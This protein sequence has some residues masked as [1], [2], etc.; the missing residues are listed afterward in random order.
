MDRH[1]QGVLDLAQQ[2]GQVI[3]SSTAPRGYPAA[4]KQDFTRE[5]VA[6]HPEHVMVFVGLE[7]IQSKDDMA[8][9]LEDVLETSLVSEAQSEQLLIA[10]QKIGDGTLG[11]GNSALL[12]DAMDFGDGAMLM[13]AQGADE[14]DDVKAEFAVG[15]GPCTFLFRAN[16]LAVTWAGRIVAA[17]DAQGQASDILECGDRAGSVV[18]SPKCAATGRTG[19]CD[20]LQTERASDGWTFRSASH[21]LLR[22]LANRL[23]G[24]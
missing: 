8:L 22:S 16:G 4:G 14:R 13:L 3:L 15:Q 7:T 5:R 20:R 12:Q 19:P 2:V 17:A 18:A 10:L 6:Q 9:L 24:S 21:D 23:N 11:D 1:G